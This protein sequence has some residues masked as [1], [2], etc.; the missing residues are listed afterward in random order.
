VFRTRNLVFRTRN[1]VLRT[2]NLVLRTRNL[3]LRTRNLVLRTRNLVLR[4]WNLVFRTRNFMLR[5]RNFMLRTT[6]STIPIR[7]AA[8]VARVGWALQCLPYKLVTCVVK[9]TPCASFKCVMSVTCTSLNI[10]LQSPKC[11]LR[12]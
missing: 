3:V 7:K 11:K 9:N 10:M 6:N 1:L 4:T 5:T 8:R 2:R 12:H